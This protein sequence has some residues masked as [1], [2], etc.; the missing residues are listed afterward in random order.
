MIYHRALSKLLTRNNPSCSIFYGVFLDFEVLAGGVHILVSSSAA[1]HH[2]PHAVS[3]G[4]AELLEVGE[5][6][7]G[8]QGRDDALQTRDA[9]ESCMKISNWRQMLNIAFRTEI[10][11]T[12]LNQL[13]RQFLNSPGKTNHT[14][15]SAQEQHRKMRHIN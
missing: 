6:M 7:G 1:V 5:G 13:L 12:L 3:Q 2:H 15:A 11:G 10:V 4:W 8:L 14:F 9:L